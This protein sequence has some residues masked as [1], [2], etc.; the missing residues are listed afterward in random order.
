MTTDEAISRLVAAG[1]ALVMR[2]DPTPIPITWWRRVHLGRHFYFTPGDDTFS[3]H[4]LDFDRERVIHGGDAVEFR[5]KDGDLVAYL[6]PIGEQESDPEAAKA[7][8]AEIA[9][10]KGRFA[11]DQNLRAFVLAEYGRAG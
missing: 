3:G 8:A 11:Q 7:L 6:A 9:E 10:W 1:A 4:A 2:T 5:A